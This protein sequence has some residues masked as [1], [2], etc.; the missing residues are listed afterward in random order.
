MPP[1]TDTILGADS[2]FRRALCSK[3]IV[4]RN[5]SILNYTQD[6]LNA[7]VAADQQE[8]IGERPFGR[9]MANP[10]LTYDM[11]D[12][13]LHDAEL[14]VGVGL[15]WV[16]WNS[17]GPSATARSTLFLYN[18]FANDRI[19]TKIGYNINDFEFIGLQLGGLLSTGSQGVY[20]VLPYEAALSHFP[21]GAPATIHRSPRM[22]PNVIPRN[23]RPAN[24]LR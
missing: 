11:R 4:L 22:F 9:L 3:G 10:M 14:F 24:L 15:N 1:F 5:D 6:I 17:A 2:G 18:A 21:L 23:A 8:Y 16:S 20:A 12:L 13:H 7:P 19:E